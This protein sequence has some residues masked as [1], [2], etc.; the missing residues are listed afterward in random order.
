GK[1][2]NFDFTTGN[3]E[4]QKENFEELIKDRENR[5]FLDVIYHQQGSF[6]TKL[7]DTDAAVAAYNKSIK[8]FKQNQ[9]LQAL[10]YS[11]LGD[12]YFDLAE[13]KTAGSYYDTTLQR[14]VENTREHRL[15]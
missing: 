15:I 6:Y 3:A 1:I 4:E 14:M 5:P 8:E 7:G 9:K 13:Y 2:N 10:N 12:I 11:S